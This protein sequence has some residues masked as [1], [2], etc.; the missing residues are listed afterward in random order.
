MKRGEEDRVGYS[1]SGG[2]EEI[3]VERRGGIPRSG[4]PVA[5]AGV[6]VAVDNHAMR[7]SCSATLAWFDPQRSVPISARNRMLASSRL[8]FLKQFKFSGH[9]SFHQTSSGR[10]RHRPRLV[11]LGIVRDDHAGGRVNN[12]AMCSAQD[13]IFGSAGNPSAKPRSRRPSVVAGW[14]VARQSSL[15]SANGREM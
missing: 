11:F 6:A 15:L 7:P 12:V 10:N 5:F 14:R 4:Q 3:F 13:V 2:A 1:G 9:L 8:L